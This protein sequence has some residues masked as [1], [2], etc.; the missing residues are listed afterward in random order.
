MGANVNLSRVLKVFRD[1]FINLKINVKENQDLSLPS[2]AKNLSLLSL[3]LSSVH[4]RNYIRVRLAFL[5][6]SHVVPAV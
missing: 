2:P 3:A 5:C 4:T 6:D 1:L